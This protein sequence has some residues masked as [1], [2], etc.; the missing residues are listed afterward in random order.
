MA[1][2]NKTQDR[3]KKYKKRTMNGFPS[4]ESAILLIL[5]KCECTTLQSSEIN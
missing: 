1:T 4:E 3:E 5:Y 2:S